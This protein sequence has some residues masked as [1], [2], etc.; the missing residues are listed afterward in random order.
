MMTISTN[1]IPGG[2]VVCSLCL[3]AVL[4]GG[5]EAAAQLHAIED[6]GD[7]GGQGEAFYPSDMNN[8]GQWAGVFA[9]LEIGNALIW[10]PTNGAQHLGSLGGGGSWAAAINDAAQ[11]A[12]S[13]ANSTGESHAFLWDATSGMQDL[14]S[15]GG[16]YSYASDINAAGQVV[17]QSYLDPSS[18]HAFL[19]DAT[20]GMQDL[21]ALAGAYSWAEGIND[22]GQVVGTTY[23]TSGYYHAFLWEPTGGMQDLGTLGGNSSNAYDINNA[24]QVVGV[25]RICSGDEHAFLWDATGGMQDL[26]TLGGLFSSAY[27]INN[28][29]QVAGLS[30]TGSGAEHLFLWDATGGMQDLGTLGYDYQEVLAISD[31][32]LVAGM[33]GRFAEGVL[34]FTWDSVNGLQEVSI[35]PAGCIPE[36]INAL[37][38]V[39]G[40][41]WTSAGEMRAFRH[42]SPGG[43]Q[44]LGTLGGD[45]SAAYGINSAGQVA[46]LSGVMPG[47]M[48]LHGFLWDATGGM[49]DLGTLGG[50]YSWARDV[51]ATGQVVGSSPT[52]MGPEHAFLWDATGGMQDLGTLGGMHSVA[53]GINSAGQ[54]VGSSAPCGPG[55]RA[56]LWDATGGMQD[57][58]TLGGVFSSAYAINDLGQVVGLSEP[59]PDAWLYHA[60]LWDATSGMQ[61]LGT[62]GGGS[63][64]ATAINDAGQAVGSSETSANQSH[65]FLWDAAG[66]LQDLNSFVRP[67]DAGWTLMTAS[68]INSNGEVVGVAYNAERVIGYR[69]Y[70]PDY[71]LATTV[72]GVGS[73][74]VDPPGGVYQAGTDV[75]LTATPGPGWAFDHWE[76]GHSATDATTTVVMDWNKLVTA[77]FVAQLPPGSVVTLTMAVSG[78]GTTLPPP[79]A[80]VY[81]GGTT[82]ELLA[83]PDP[84]WAFSGWSGLG[85]TDNPVQITLYTDKTVTAEFVPSGFPFQCPVPGTST[86]APTTAGPDVLLLAL[87]AVALF[88]YSRFARRRS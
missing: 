27:A 76:G 77:V 86:Q 62:L 32:G 12:G 15:L 50:D 17:G 7:L 79:G 72:L 28:A 36:G 61:D 26:G 45:Y 64:E 35:Y 80:N 5:V 47:A 78:S 44:G 13:S 85:T 34:A 42:N 71:T 57:L 49:Q 55:Q 2:Y 84:G 63:S 68:D 81:L 48:D 46:G 14:G 11:V 22:S 53:Y 65:A 60:F 30:L 9:L 70:M 23:T 43:M 1:R 87:A 88:G 6:L 52:G 59:M 51:N 58:G 73:V 74:A 21:G 19:W 20:G 66:G 8:T 4:L 69:L 33:A 25:S 3:V 41:G 40:A 75:T 54:V 38:Q 56:F 37:S 82:V 10:D 16:P 39:V 24:G 83:T 29:G 18:Y 67:A 31:A